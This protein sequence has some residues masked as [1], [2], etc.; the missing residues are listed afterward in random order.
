MG[1]LNSNR[2][3]N[4]K[5]DLHQSPP[6]SLNHPV[7]RIISTNLHQSPPIQN[8]YQ[9]L[10]ISTN[11]H[12]SPPIIQH[13]VSS[14]Q[15]PVST[16]QY[17]FYPHLSSVLQFNLYICSGWLRFLSLKGNPVQN[18]YCARSCKSKQNVVIHATFPV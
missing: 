7:S 18:R 9:S 8:L 10:S 13:P 11:L 4:P 3:Q 6:I 16:I 14:I 12:Q 17:L 2:I 5:S 1:E 15:H